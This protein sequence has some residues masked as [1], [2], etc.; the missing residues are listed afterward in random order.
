MERMSYEPPMVVSLGSVRE[1]TL[2]LAITSS[3]GSM[4]VSIAAPT[5]PPAP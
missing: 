2:G 5:A 3:D 4:G 1:V